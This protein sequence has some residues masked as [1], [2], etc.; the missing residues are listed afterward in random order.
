M[1]IPG[2]MVFLLNPPVPSDPDPLSSEI[3]V[4][5]EVQTEILKYVGNFYILNFSSE[6]IAFF[7]LNLSY[8]IQE[9]LI[10]FVLIF[11]LVT[12]ILGENF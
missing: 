6:L 11:N 8:I 5:F 1:E 2:G 4:S 3:P 12:N 7:A 9:N 10:I